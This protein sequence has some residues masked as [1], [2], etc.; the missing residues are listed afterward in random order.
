MTA[1]RGRS[2]PFAATAA[3][4]GALEITAKA[5]ALKL[6]PDSVTVNIVAPGFI[7]KEFRAHLAIDPK[8]LQD[9]CSQ[10]PMG[11]I[12]EAHEVASVVKFCASKESSYL[13][14]QVIHVNGGLV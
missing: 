11:R 8:A 12:G 1:W 2:T 9:V 4:K 3:A 6:A 5:L 7:K 13:T 14:G 10:I